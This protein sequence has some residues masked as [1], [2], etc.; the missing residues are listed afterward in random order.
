MADME[1]DMDTVEACMGMEVEGGEVGL[2]TG[3]PG[4]AWALFLPFPM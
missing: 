2:V 4:L 3:P 1:E